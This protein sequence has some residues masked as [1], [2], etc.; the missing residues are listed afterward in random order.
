M[1]ASTYLSRSVQGAQ[2]VGDGITKIASTVVGATIGATTNLL[3]SAA[4]RT[5]GLKYAVQT[6]VHRWVRI[7][8]DLYFLSF[9][10]LSPPPPGPL[11]ASGTP[12]WWC[13]SSFTR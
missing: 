2:Q 1:L 10:L 12:T 6:Y 9:I 4:S 5:P 11:V 8:Y 7:Q 13:G 3:V